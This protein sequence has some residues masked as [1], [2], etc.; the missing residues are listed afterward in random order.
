[1]VGLTPAHAVNEHA[2]LLGAR[3]SLV[4]V[5]A[6]AAAPPSAERPTVVILNSGIVHRVG[7][8]RMS[9]ALARA[10][11]AAG[12]AA[13]RFDLSGLGD[14][15]P[16]P[17]ALPPLE[18]S[19]ADIR[20]VLDT[21][22]ATRGAKRVILAGLCSGADHSLVYAGGD[23]RVV[24]AVL[25]D[26]SVPRT[27]RHHLHHYGR[28]LFVR[29]SWANLARGAN[30]LWRSLRGR[31]EGWAPPRPLDRDHPEVRAFLDRAYRTALEAGV[32]FLAVVSGERCLYRDQIFDAFPHTRSG[33]GLELEYLATSDHMFSAQADSRRVIRR[34]V[35][36]VGTTPFAG[37]SAAFPAAAP[38]RVPR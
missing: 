15:P 12:H 16:R 11:A 17:E 9:V 14:S 30:P 4:G 34:V 28:R 1:M 3:R 23:P 31:V 25:L 18:A 24:G 22:E 35:D 21:L 6:E 29:E 33:D 36:W 8:N 32:R 7:A 26:P 37:A 38:L 19:L 20:D 2:L 10:L 27:L 13:L 5:I